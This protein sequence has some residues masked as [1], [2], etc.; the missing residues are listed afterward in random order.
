MNDACTAAN[1]TLISS[2][3]RSARATACAASSEPVRITKPCRVLELT[4]SGS[5]SPTENGK[6]SVWTKSRRVPRRRRTPTAE[7][8]WEAQVGDVPDG[9][10]LAQPGRPAGEGGEHRTLDVESPCDLD[11]V[12]DLVP[13]EPGL[14]LHDPRPVRG[15]G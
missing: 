7:P 1:S 14:R 3:T 5:T 6:F 2:R 11:D 4:V 9:L 15:A 13:A 8:R 10:R 12:G